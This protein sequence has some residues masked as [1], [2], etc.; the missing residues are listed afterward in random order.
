MLTVGCLRKLV[1]L[2]SCV[3][4]QIRCVALGKEGHIFTQ[5]RINSHFFR[6]RTY[7]CRKR[8]EVVE[9]VDDEGLHQK[10][11]ATAGQHSSNRRAVDRQQIG[12]PVRSTDVHNMHRGVAVDRST[13]EGELSTARS[14]D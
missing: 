2:L 9:E 10:E 8:E 5:N 1:M 6:F 14:T 7:M 13:A 3:I 4:K 11:A 12:R